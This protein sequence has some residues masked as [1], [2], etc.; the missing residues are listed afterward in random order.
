MQ[1]NHEMVLRDLEGSKH[2]KADLEEKIPK[3]KL[4]PG[5]II[6]LK[7]CTK[8]LKLIMQ[9]EQNTSGHDK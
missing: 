7:Y 1:Q 3:C 5:A 6:G 8:S 2:Q 4:C 9:R